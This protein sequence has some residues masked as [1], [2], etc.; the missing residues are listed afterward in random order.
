[1]SVGR[2]RRAPLRARGGPARGVRA[3]ARRG[4]G[5]RIV[6]AAQGIRAGRAAPTRRRSPTSLGNP[7]AHGVLAADF[8]IDRGRHRA[9]AR[10]AGASVRRTWWSARPTGITAVVPVDAGGRFTSEV[11]G[12]RRH[13]G[14]RRQP[15]DHPGPQGRDGGGA[16]RLGQPG[17]GA[18]AARDLRPLL[19]ALLAL[20]QPADLQ[21]RQQLV[22]RGHQVQATGWSSSTSRSPGCPST[23]RTASSASGCPTRATGRSAETASGAAR[24]RSGSRDDPAYPRVD[25]YGSL[26]ELEADFGVAGAPTC[27]G[28]T[29]TS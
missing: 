2:A 19:P 16:G 12:L 15:G 26:A 18:A 24:S 3:R 17:H 7:E 22:R 8:V 20:P 29:S 13:A 23:S 1:M 27:T 28:R 14:L 21:A 5:E 6:A 10:V 25:V 4:R 9:G 11:A